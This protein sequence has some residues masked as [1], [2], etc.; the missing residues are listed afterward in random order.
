MTDLPRATY[1]LQL[2]AGFTLDDAAAVLPYLE[3]LGISHAYLSPI[4][5]ARPGSTHGYD[6]IDHNVINP[7]LG[8]EPAWQRFVAAAHA[9]GLK[10]VV[11]IVP[12]HVGV[13]GAG[14]AWWLDVLEWGAQ[15]PFA[16]RFDIRWYSPAAGLAGQLL[17]PLL[18]R[19]YGEALE[20]GDLAV[21]FDAEEGSLS[22]W[23][24]GDHRLPL[25]PA[26]YGT[27]L[28][29]TLP[30]LRDLFRAQR[31]VGD[32]ARPQA[33]ALKRALAEAARDPAVGARIA[34]RLERLNG[35]P[36]DAASFDALD[37]LIAR[38]HWRAAS[39]RVAAD[40]INYRRFFNINDL[41]GVRVEEEDIFEALHARVLERCARGEI[42]GLRVD[43]IDGL[44]D[45]AEYCR[46]LR[47]KA[48]EGCYLVVEKILASHE[49]L[50]PW[51][52]QGTTGYEYAAL[53]TA[54]FVDERAAVAFTRIYQDFTGDTQGF[55]SLVADCKRLV[56]RRELASE[57]AVLG[58]M[59]RDI[60]QQSRRSRD[61]TYAALTEALLEIIA[62]FPVYRS[63]VSAT[64]CT[65]TDLRHIE[66]ACGRARRALPDVDESVIAFLGLLMQG[67]TGDGATPAALAFA[68]KVQQ[69]T[70]PVMAK[71]MEDTAF[72]RY[73]RLL[74]LNEVG[75]HPA[76]FGLSVASFH[77]VMQQRAVQMPHA[78]LA[79]TTHD[80]KR[81]ED[82]RAR[83]AALSGFAAEWEQQLRA[84]VRL[85]RARRG[86]VSAEAPPD[87]LDEYALLQTLLA[88]WPEPF[89]HE[90]PV[91][92]S[93]EWQAFGERVQGAA[94]KAVREGKR[95]S[96]WSNPDESYEAAL[97]SWIETALDVARPNLFIEQFR[98]FV[99]RVAAQGDRITLA[100]AVLRLTV[101]GV[102][103][104]YQGS[105]RGDF[106]M[107]DPDNRRPVDFETLT[108]E[109]EQ[110]TLAK[111][112]WVARLLGWRRRC[113][114]LFAGG[115]YEP[116]QV[117]GD[118]GGSVLA[119]E[120]NANG[121]RLLVIIV[122]DTRLLDEPDRLASLRFAGEASGESGEWTD[123]LD[124]HRWSALPSPFELLRD[125]PATALVRR[126][127]HE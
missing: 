92:D 99:A 15:S 68:S 69:Y 74:A 102:P 87:A 88:A 86:G 112:R 89:L 67:R 42:D 110:G 33:D 25:R 56:M 57:L 94:L 122:L 49:S 23:L 70:G 126:H 24:P 121:L 9:A 80:T 48:P 55:D 50:P 93:P 38:Q 28:G 46:R 103:D 64:S 120:R 29:A 8:G 78:L 62:F 11:D 31:E 2:H 27:V 14:N 114:E 95:H 59:A 16:R 98:P 53:A 58:R 26:D 71:G 116:L 123:V 7:E 17:V 12:N 40:E 113:P 35:D 108:A 66:W 30:G 44:Y 117:T 75:S 45:P 127:E 101:P 61:F 3:R 36:G 18:G 91:A 20:A 81:G 47:E 82:G 4:S 63:Y 115:T 125:R 109:L 105:E 32:E 111:Q 76:S 37:R 5:A 60:A 10:I 73:Q 65:E 77:Q 52:V 22:V 39:Y 96:T 21:R 90:S 106:S 79:G 83:L 13:G 1:R 43:H 107:V 104:I 97:R 6:V 34:A 41:A 54:L 84:A 118:Q 85:I 100:E 19:Q 124:D 51:P 72:Y 119:F